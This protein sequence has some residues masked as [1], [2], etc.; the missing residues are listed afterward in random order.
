MLLCVFTP[1]IQECLQ[2]SKTPSTQSKAILL[3]AVRHYEIENDEFPDRH[4]HAKIRAQIPGNDMAISTW[5]Q[6]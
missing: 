2:Q 6:N 5:G 3:L 4:R 1:S